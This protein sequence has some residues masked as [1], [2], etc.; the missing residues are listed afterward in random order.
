MKSKWSGKIIQSNRK[1]TA[2]LWNCN[3]EVEANTSPH[4]ILHEQLHAFDKLLQQRNI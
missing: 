4:A 1:I 2:K 3:I